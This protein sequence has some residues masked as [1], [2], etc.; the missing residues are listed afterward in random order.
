MMIDRTVQPENQQ[1]I[2][3]SHAVPLTWHA[4][5]TNVEKKNQPIILLFLQQQQQQQQQQQSCFQI[6]HSIHSFIESVRF[7]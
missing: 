6:F 2:P 7:W 4:S 1:Q 5:N 3:E